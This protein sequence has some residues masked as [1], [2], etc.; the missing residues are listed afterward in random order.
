MYDQQYSAQIAANEMDSCDTMISQGSLSC[1]TDF[2]SGGDYA[3]YCDYSCGF[4]TGGGGGTGD[5]VN[6]YDQQFSDEIAAM[7]MDSCDNIISQGSLS[8]ATDF[9]PG[10]D[11]AGYCDYSCGIC[12]GSGGSS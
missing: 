12:T 9:A 3:G 11:Y 4:C 7:E 8:C 2:A 1:A 6:M 10:G 5:C